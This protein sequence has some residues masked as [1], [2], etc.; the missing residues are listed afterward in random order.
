MRTRNRRGTNHRFPLGALLGVTTMLFANSAAGQG[1]MPSRFTSPVIGSDGEVYKRSGQWQIAT[2]FRR[3]S[4]DEKIV[5]NAVVDVPGGSPEVDVSSISV[6]VWYGVSERLSLSLSVPFSKG[7]HTRQYAD[8]ARHTNTASGVGDISL[9][10]NYW[11]LALGPGGNIGL[12]VGLKAPT[13]RNDAQGKSW[14]KD[15]STFAIPVVPAIQ[16]GD[17]GWGV[18][19]QAQGFRPILSRTYLY[20]S[21]TYIANRGTSKVPIAPASPV[22]WSIPDS[23][24]ASA[25]VSVALWPDHGF[26]GNL[27]VRLSGTPQNNLIGGKDGGQ[28]L[29]ATVG[30]VDPGITLR[31]GA[32]T[33]SLSVPV[34]AYYRFPP[35]AADVAAGNKGGGG[36]SNHQILATYA[37]RF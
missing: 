31:L 26:S 6:G 12:G 13:G 16:L 11:L 22:F 17:G 9:V 32:N 27:G 21:A 36:L 7:S 4:S 34:R 8:L 23:W 30:Y 14:S 15:G 19:L 33:F 5:G 25:G 24:S 3:Y 29:P 18:F 37:V 10:A 35:S 2:T 28:R 20:V 1:C